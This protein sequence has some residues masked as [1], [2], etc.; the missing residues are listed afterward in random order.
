MKKSLICWLILHSFLTSYTQDID[1]LVATAVARAEVLRIQE[2]DNAGAIE[3]LQQAL[4]EVQAQGVPDGPSL[5]PLYHKIGVNYYS[6]GKYA[7]A[8]SYLSKALSIRE[9]TYGRVHVDVAKGYYVRALVN[10][11]L[12]LYD[13]AQKD[14]ETAISSMEKVLELGRS[15]ED[16]RLIWMFEECI[17]LQAVLKNNTLALQYWERAY[18]YY[19]QNE[20]ANFQDIIILYDLKGLIYYNQQKYDLSED[21]YNYAIQLF[22]QYGQGENLSVPVATVYSHFGIMQFQR[23]KYVE[24]TRNYE[25]ARGVFEN[26]LQEQRS[27]WIYQNLGVVHANLLELSGKL[28]QYDQ[29]DQH[30]NKA[31]EYYLQGY[32]TFYHPNVATLYRDYAQLEADRGN[33]RVALALNQKSIQALIPD[34]KTEDPLQLVDLSKYVIK[35]KIACLESLRQRAKLLM[36]ISEQESGAEEYL[37]SA[38]QNYL[39]LDTIITQVRQSYNAA[40]SQFDLIEQSYPIYERAIEASLLLYERE[41]EQ[42]YLE[43]AYY[44]A[45]RNK[46]LVLLGGMQEQQARTDSA[47]PAELKEQERNLKK[48]ILRLESR[49][50]DLQGEGESAVLKD[51]LFNL[52]REHQKLISRFETEFPD[53]YASK[54]GF[55]QELKLSDFQRQL[56]WE[57]AVVEYFVGEEYLFSFVITKEG[58]DYRKIAKPANFEELAW[59][60]REQIQAQENWNEAALGAS[61]Q[62]Y[63]WLLSR[64]LSRPIITDDVKHLVI[65]PDGVLMQLPFDVLIEDPASSQLS[66]LLRRYAISYAYS[67]RL[68]TGEKLGTSASSTFAGFGLEYDDYT[69][70][71]LSAYTEIET[72]N[73]ADARALGKLQYSDDEIQE[74]ATLLSGDQ[75][76]NTNAT[77]TSFLENADQ[78]AILHL[79]MHGVL[80]EESPMN[81]ALVFTRQNDSTEYLLRAGDLYNMKLKAD[82]T[83]LSACNTG[84]GTLQKGEGVRSLAR[85][86]SYAGCPSLIASLW[87]ASDR[88]TK[89]ILILFYENLKEGMSKH[90]AMRRAKLAYLDSSPPAY[91]SPYYWSHLSV[92]GDSSE[93]EVLS[94]SRFG[95]FAL[96]IGLPLLILGGLFLWYRRKSR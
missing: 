25:I 71:G 84:A 26:L 39:T 76:I 56:K 21:A 57:T 68:L 35:D 33:T 96:P 3:I 5:M 51:S 78:Y 27:P 77:K 82:M 12:Q 13:E 23:G 4:T 34:V 53:Y 80:N 16:Y 45:A 7:E 58:F 17:S 38:F 81:S 2:G 67:N 19:A 24:A 85:A 87:N 61:H 47:I 54:Y 79:A 65:I 60:F 92:I 49:L 94:G 66:Y 40:G 44:F 70:A 41:E 9:E 62:L 93:L 72:S 55:G 86:F 43:T 42:A 32:E 11:E 30:F 1:T 8:E 88:S 90:E 15:K 6:F 91:Q 73:L 75:W 29:V 20:E 83:V 89:D 69:L 52:Q 63:Q 36:D 74:I 28:G 18:D 48:S 31:L 95:R 14:L 10:R 22:E 37:A 59:R 50:Y 46:A 64:V